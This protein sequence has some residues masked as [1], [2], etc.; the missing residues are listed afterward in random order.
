MGSKGQQVRLLCSAPLPSFDGERI[1]KPVVRQDS[2]PELTG[3]MLVNPICMPLNLVKQNDFDCIEMFC[4]KGMG[5][6]VCK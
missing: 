2:D 5:R 4:R 6:I 3:P 1:S